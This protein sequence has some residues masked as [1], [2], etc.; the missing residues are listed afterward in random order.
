[1]SKK[2]NYL[3]CHRNPKT[4]NELRQVEAAKDEDVEIKN[5]VRAKRKKRYLPN[6][7]DDLTNKKYRLK[8]PIKPRGKKKSDKV[9]YH[10]K[11]MRFLQKQAGENL[12]GLFVNKTEG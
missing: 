7:W 9:K 11:F 2:Y 12:K 10:K 5:A 6:A 4:T 8:F 3:H 1:M